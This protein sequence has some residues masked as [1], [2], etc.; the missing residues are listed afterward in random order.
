MGNQRVKVDGSAAGIT[1]EMLQS[2][3]EKVIRAHHTTHDQSGPGNDFLGWVNWPT[4]YDQEE[5]KRLKHVA[6]TIRKNADVLLVIGIGGSYLGAKAALDALCH[7]FYNQLPKE[8]RGGPEVQ[9]VGQNISGTYLS[10]LLETLE[11]KSVYVNII[12]KS[13]TTTE[14]ALAFRIIRRYLAKVYGETE[15]NK[16]IIATTDRSQGA[17]RTFADQNGYE[18]FVIPDDIGGRY[19][20]FTPVGL[21]PMAV[22]G[23]DTDAVLAGAAEGEV[24]YSNPSL[25]DNPAYQYAAM[26]YML[27]HNQKLIEILV[28]YEP[29]LASVSE[30]WKQ[31][32]GE[33]EGKD[34]KGLF[35]ASL[36]FSTDLH[37]MGQY[38]QDGNRILFETVLQVAQ[39]A[40][41]CDVPHE[42][43]DLDQLNFLSGKSMSSVNEMAFKGTLLAHVDGG[44]PNIVLTIPTLDAASFGQLLYFFMKACAISGYM[45]EVNPFNQPGVE[46]YKKNMFALLGKKGYEALAD[47]LN[48]RL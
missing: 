31:L 44:V 6:Q 25:K 39:P 17:L 34:G 20:I 40:I 42:E 47:Q 9:F 5:Y 3:E 48:K 19:S 30:W 10:Q 27:H 32:Y 22:A 26:R 13:G 15:A 16:R 21:L 8:K 37:S 1:M 28:S 41:D 45:L 29:S 35:P 24:L 43:S 7:S 2:L 18:T 46:A 33:S 14:P 4:Q 23:I 12:S 38:V 36:V 11:G